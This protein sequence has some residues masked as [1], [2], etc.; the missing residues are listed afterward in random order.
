MVAFILGVSIVS[1]YELWPR[2]M[3]DKRLI[4]FLV[5]DRTIVVLHDKY[6]G[7]TSNMRGVILDVMLGLVRSTI[8]G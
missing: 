3:G 4:K 1:S 6:Y 7:T 5:C 8:I 2:I